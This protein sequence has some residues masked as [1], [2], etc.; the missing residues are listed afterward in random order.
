[1]RKRTDP[2]FGDRRLFRLDEV[3]KVRIAGGDPDVRGW[4]VVTSDHRKVG[5]VHEL[6]VDMEAMRV[7]YVDVSVDARVLGTRDSSHVLLPIDNAE[8]DYDDRR[9]Y[10]ADV[11]ADRLLEIPSYDHRPITR[12]YEETLEMI[13]RAVATPHEER[14]ARDVESRDRSHV[15]HELKDEVIPYPR[16]RS[17]PPE[18][19]DDE[20]LPRAG[21][22]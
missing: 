2:R 18:P 7:R 12:K 9:V 11:P 16:R 8:L 20:L 10:F 1:M 14:P 22:R 19:D 4:D 3:R 5:R 6:V 15:A 13:S 21:T 17:R